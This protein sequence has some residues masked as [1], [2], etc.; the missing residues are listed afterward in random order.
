MAL[1]LSSFIVI[2]CESE[3]VQNELTT[4]VGFETLGQQ[5]STYFVY[6][7]TDKELFLRWIGLR[8]RMKSPE[9]V[10][11]LMFNEKPVGAKWEL[12]LADN[13]KATHFATYEYNESTGVDRVTLVE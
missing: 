3:F 11:V 12:P 5:G 7:D 9:Q 10:T 6:A 2:G 8:F 1:V 13:V 4:G